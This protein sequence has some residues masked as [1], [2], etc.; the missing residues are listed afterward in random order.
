MRSL[1][2]I[3]NEF[4][5]TE[6][7]YD[8]FD[9]LDPNDLAETFV[10]RHLGEIARRKGKPVDSPA[11]RNRMIG[12]VL[13]VFYS[14]LEYTP[15]PACTF[16][17]ISALPTD[18]G[19]R[20]AMFALDEYLAGTRREIRFGDSPDDDLTALMSSIVSGDELTASSYLEIAS[21]V[22]FTAVTAVWDRLLDFP[23][24]RKG[25]FWDITDQH[26]LQLVCVECDENGNALEDVEYSSKSGENFN[27]KAEWAK[28]PRSVTGGHDFDYYPRGRVEI[29]NGKATLW[30]PPSLESAVEVIKT[31]F[32]LTFSD[33]DFEYKLDHSLHYDPKCERED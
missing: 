26:C 16:Y 31:E 19:M 4:R 32:G 2:D 12:R 20:T 33:V 1:S 24:L 6:L 11:L 14:L 29:K 27:H 17:V 9:E 30:I 22:I 28:L 3:I 23:P 25:I 5:K 15:N 21:D 18:G 13:G 10:D 7:F 8:I